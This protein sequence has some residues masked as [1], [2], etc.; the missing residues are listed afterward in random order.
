MDEPGSAGDSGAA[1]GG[2]RLH[3]RGALGVDDHRDV[4]RCQCACQSDAEPDARP[5]LWP[6]DRV[7]TPHGEGVV[8][9]LW[10]GYV[11]VLSL[12]GMG[13]KTWMRDE[14]RKK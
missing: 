12:E 11:S 10:S 2:R 5:A 4:A 8:D 3:D 14:V 6:N 1:A 7:I 13:L 9:S